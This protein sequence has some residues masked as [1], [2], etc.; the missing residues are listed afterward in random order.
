M[1]NKKILLLGYMRRNLG[2]DLFIAMLLNR[3]KDIEF[4]VRE[5]SPKYSEPF[6]NYKN[7]SVVKAEGKLV[8]FDTKDYVACVY[9]G[10]S[11]LA[12]TKNG[13]TN[14]KTI[15]GFLENLFESIAITSLSNC[16]IFFNASALISSVWLIRNN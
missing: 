1:I 14:Q 10:G 3:Y 2:D 9:I 6:K 13:M 15:N 16:M 11:V 5:T 7:F 12:E 4:V 8:D